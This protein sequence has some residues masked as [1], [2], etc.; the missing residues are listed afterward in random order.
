MNS[1]STEVGLH[2]TSDLPGKSETSFGRT[3]RGVS[4]NKNK[5]PP[6]AEQPHSNK[7]PLT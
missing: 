2:M 7:D 4:D 3:K 5:I 1:Q 6:T